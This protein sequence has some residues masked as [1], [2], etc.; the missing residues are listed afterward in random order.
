[1]VKITRAFLQYEAVSRPVLAECER[2]KKDDC[3]C[4]ENKNFT[5]LEGEISAVSATRIDRLIAALA[6]ATKPTERHYRALA[7]RDELIIRFF[8]SNFPSREGE[9]NVTTLPYGH[10]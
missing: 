7:D 3:N 9:R 10:D 6:N 5:H 8:Y 1:M 4:P 2:T